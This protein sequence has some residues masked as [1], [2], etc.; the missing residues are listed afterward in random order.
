MCVVRLRTI[1]LTRRLSLS[2]SESTCDREEEAVATAA[3][4]A[5]DT[6]LGMSR[7][8]GERANVCIDRWDCLCKGSWESRASGKLRAV[9]K[10]FH[11][12]HAQFCFDPRIL[13]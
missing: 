7:D 4:G 1:C 3:A 10:V 12:A 6:L 2:S 11:R 8:E 13:F 5:D 9:D